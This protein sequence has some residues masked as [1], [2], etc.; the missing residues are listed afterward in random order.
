MTRGR[1]VQLFLVGAVV[2]LI[3]ACGSGDSDGA[4][5][6]TSI[7]VVATEFAFNSSSAKVA[8]AQD[9]SITLK[10]S[11]VVEHEWAI[12]KAGTSIGSEAEFDESQ[13]LFRLPP[14]AAGESASNSFNMATGSYQ[15]V[16][17]IEGHF[18]A[19]MKGTL[20]AGPG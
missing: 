11:G 19:G 6:A 20:I 4:D 7:T 9:V 3:A 14:V 10:N 5:P 15:I 2:G 1:L 8:A 12:L 17:T 16:C 18:A 13:V